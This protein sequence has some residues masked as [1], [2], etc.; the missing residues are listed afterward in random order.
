MSRDIRSSIA[1]FLGNGAFGTEKLWEE[2]GAENERLNI[3]FAIRWLGAI[4]APDVKACFCNGGPSLRPQDLR[5]RMIEDE[6]I[7]KREKLE[8]V[9]GWF[10]HP[11]EEITFWRCLSRSS[12]HVL[13]LRLGEHSA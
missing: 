8:M 10:S 7:K 4:R 11:K 6:I 13:T 5:N 1:L 3:F 12:G 9:S 2:L